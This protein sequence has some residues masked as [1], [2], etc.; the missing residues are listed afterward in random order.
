MENG[1]TTTVFRHVT[2]DYYQQNLYERRKQVGAASIAHLCKS[3]L[4][5]NTRCRNHD[6]SNPLDSLYYLVCVQ[7]VAKLDAQRIYHVVRDL[8]HGPKKAFHF[9]VADAEDSIRLTGFPHG[10][11]SPYGMLTKIPIILDSRILELNPPSF[12]LGGGHIDTKLGCHIDEFINHFH[13]VIAQVSDPRPKDYDG[14]NDDDDDVAGKDDED[15][16]DD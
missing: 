13:P 4:V 16:P 9:R 1:F 15:E 11:V 2:P 12:W 5:L 3:I 7:Y 8:T 6:C 10:A 14:L